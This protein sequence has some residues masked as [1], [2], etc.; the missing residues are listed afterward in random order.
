MTLR[1]SIQRFV[2][3][4][5]CCWSLLVAGLRADRACGQETLDAWVPEGYLAAAVFDGRPAD[6]PSLSP[7]EQETWRALHP[8]YASLL[9]S[10][11][12]INWDQMPIDLREAWI[13]DN[14]GGSLLSSQMAFYVRPTEGAGGGLQPTGGLMVSEG[15]FARWMERFTRMV[16]SQSGKPLERLRWNDAKVQR[17]Q[18]DGLSIEFGWIEERFV[19]TLGA[20]DELSWWMEQRSQGVPRTWTEGLERTA[21]EKRWLAASLD[22]QGALEVASITGDTEPLAMMERIGLT[23]MSTLTLQAGFDE[24]GY[25]HRAWVAC[26][27]GPRGVFQ[28]FAPSDPGEVLAAVATDQA[29]TLTTGNHLFDQMLELSAGLNEGNPPSQLLT[30]LSEALGP[31]VLIQHSPEDGGL[32]AGLTVIF[33]V[34]NAKRAGQLEQELLDSIEQRIEAMQGQWWGVP[35]LLRS[36]FEGAEVY[37]YQN[38]PYNP[39]TAVSWSLN[40]EYLVIGQNPV[41]LKPT[42]QRLSQNL[43]VGVLPQGDP[44]GLDLRFQLSKLLGT[45]SGFGQFFARVA[46]HDM[47]WQ[48]RGDLPWNRISGEMVSSLPD[49]TQLLPLLRNEERITLTTRQDGV[50]LEARVSLPGSELLLLG[51]LGVGGFVFAEEAGVD[52]TAMLMPAEASRR[53]RMNGLRQI[54]LAM[55]N[56][57]DTFNRFPAQSFKD[58]NG[59]PLLSWRVAILPYI[60]Q[61]TLYDQFHFDEPWDSEHNLSLLDK[62]PAIYRTT[63]SED[64]PFHTN[65]QVI[66][67]GNSIFPADSDGERIA[68]I[69]DGTSNTFMVLESTDEGAVEWTRPDDIVPDMDLWTQLFGESRDS[70]MAVF[71]DGAVHVIP[72]ETTAEELEAFLTRNGGEVI[73]W[74][75]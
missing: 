62:M 57:H 49:S 43:E 5:A 12:I 28:M 27:E 46:V 33:P 13:D 22:F 70:F 60:E 4:S 9:L 25:V 47:S 21:L 51:T 45:P 18:V 20:R 56:Y 61:Q 23:S 7:R 35:T 73:N 15:A 63:A 31:G 65:F 72:S 17:A 54:G 39:F 52:V 2:V 36:E 53:D 67:A 71:A 11:P 38:Q 40:D 8:F 42:L 6:D 30:K 69:F 41:A 66:E 1:R 19:V 64:R 48:R 75:E 24:E 59:R 37:T 32:I 44:V 34:A 55:H 29:A 58:E 50:E 68:S 16:V 74:R 26:P 14:V 10:V 3:S